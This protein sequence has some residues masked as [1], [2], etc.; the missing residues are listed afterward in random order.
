MLFVRCAGGLSHHPGES[1][2]ADDAQVALDVLYDMVR[3]LA[4]S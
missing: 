3:G 1:V 2:S 4:E